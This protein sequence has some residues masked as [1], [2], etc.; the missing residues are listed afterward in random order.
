M[1]ISEGLPH[2]S[3]SAPTHP[4]M[5]KLQRLA[6]LVRWVSVGYAAWVLWNILD[7]WLD[8]DKVA[9]NY[10]NFIHR[11]LSALA[12]S[13]RYAA[14]ALDLLAWTLLLL[15]VMH[16]WKFLNDLSQPA[17]WSG[18]AARHLSLC[19]WFA[20]ACEGFSELARPLQSYFLTLHLSA[21]EQVWKWNFRAV[22][23]QAVLFCLSLLMFAYVFGWTMELAEEN[24][25]F[26]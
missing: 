13:P 15:A 16:C 1:Q 5:R 23:L 19:A 8:A 12:A 26:V 14:L 18:T 21:A 25:S 17:R 4:A 3:E 6:H 7:W 22:D 24:R 20:I 10:G 9:T 11:D 2:G